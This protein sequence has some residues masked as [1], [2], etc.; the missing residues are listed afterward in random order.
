MKYRP[1]IDGLRAL[2][3]IPVVLFHAGFSLFSGGFVGVDIFFVISG[4]L[5]TSI[6]IAD[7][8]KGTFSIINF[9]ERRARRIL[10]ALFLIL[11]VCLPFAWAWMM[12]NQLKSFAR[13]MVHVLFFISNI[14]FYDES[15]YFSDISAESPL[16]HTWSLAVEEQYYILFPLLFIVLWKYGRKNVIKFIVGGLLASLALSEYGW[17]FDPVANFYLVLSRA[18][19][20]FSGSLCAFYLVDKKPIKNDILSFLGLFLIVVSIFIFDET[21]PFPSVYA[22]VPVIGACLIIVFGETR[23]YVSKILSNRCFVG[24]GLISYSVYLWHHP[25]FAF[26]RLRSLGEPSI[27]VMA[28]LSVLSVILAFFSW[29]YVESPFRK[30]KDRGGFSRKTIFATAGA[31]SFCFLVISLVGSSMKGLP[32]RFDGKMNTI[33]NAQKGDTSQCHNRFKYSIDDIKNGETC[34][35][36]DSGFTPKIAVIG[37]SHA[38]RIT[39]ALG[40]LLENNEQS[41]V[42]YNASWCVPLIGITSSQ[43][44]R[45]HCSGLIDASYDAVLNDNNI[46]TVVLVAAWAKYTSG[47]LP[48]G[49][50]ATVFGANGITPDLINNN[51]FV[52]KGALEKTLSRIKDSHKRIVIVGSVPEFTINVP[53]ALAKIQLFSERAVVKH[54][55]NKKLLVTP[56]D[57]N[58]RNE[59][60]L[61]AFEETSQRY[62]FEYIN[63]RDIY[64]SEEFCKYE[65]TEGTPFYEDTNHLSFSGS[66]PLIDALS[67]KLFM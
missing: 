19:E 16:L 46:E 23:T 6:I 54:Q 24:I 15:D 32:E 48:D 62:S 14:F 5:I 28:G 47:Y 37:D 1:E 38:S 51:P 63:P 34:I 3:V 7:K 40:R 45:R 35:I 53:Q 49:E 26:A 30:K 41:A 65:S 67:D 4:Y 59:E 9:Y 33:L 58:E 64:C 50:N 42:T 22:L 11:L 2:A 12:P 55:L 61:K 44:N 10:P 39:D 17:R 21:T 29:K 43:K 18:W 31:F 27:H 56:N 36:G 25:I 66:I 60:V 8:E 13:S 20:L 57:Y 52:F